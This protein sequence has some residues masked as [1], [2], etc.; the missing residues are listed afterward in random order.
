VKKQG[1]KNYVL[2]AKTRQSKSHDFVF[3]GAHFVYFN[4]QEFE[5]LT[6]KGPIIFPIT[7]AVSKETPGIR[8]GVEWSGLSVIFVTTSL[9]YF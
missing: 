9:P 8:E 5:R 7:V 1:T 6:V 2:N 3:A 4:D